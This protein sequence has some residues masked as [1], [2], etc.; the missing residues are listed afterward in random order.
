M[1]L[2]GYALVSVLFLLVSQNEIVSTVF[3]KETPGV[4]LEGFRYKAVEPYLLPQ[5][6]PTFTL[7][8]VPLYM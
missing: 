7:I 8:L 6:W 3:S 2:K 5:V 1:N 4:L